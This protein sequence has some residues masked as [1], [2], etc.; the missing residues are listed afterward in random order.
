MLS[1]SKASEATMSQSFTLMDVYYKEEKLKAWR[2]SCL[3]SILSG[4]KKLTRLTESF[5]EFVDKA[6]DVDEL[7]N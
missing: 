2:D 6:A 1:Q 7:A 3:K 4:N 5:E